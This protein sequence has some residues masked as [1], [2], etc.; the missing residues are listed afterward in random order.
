M[1]CQRGMWIAV[2]SSLFVCSISEARG[3]C[4]GHFNNRS[5][6]QWSISGYDGDKANLII[7]PNTAAEI[8]WGS[9]TSVVISGTITGRPYTRQ[10]QVHAADG[11]VVIEHQ[12]NTGNV[13]LN[14]PSNGDVVTCVGNC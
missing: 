6:Y 10:F 8:P 13:T 1:N 9:A 11:C 14:K 12:G 2:A 7:A 4:V 3:A 5:N